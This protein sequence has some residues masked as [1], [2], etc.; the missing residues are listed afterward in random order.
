MET[1]LTLF[2]LTIGMGIWTLIC[3][4]VGYAM[5]RETQGQVVNTKMLGG[6]D[7]KADKVNS[8]QQMWEDPWSESQEPPAHV[9]PTVREQ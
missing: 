3:I 8:E 7:R 1:L 2:S 9:K 4:R 6:R 5:G